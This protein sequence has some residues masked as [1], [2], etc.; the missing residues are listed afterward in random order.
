MNVVSGERYGMVPDQVIA[1]A[2]GHYGEPPAPIDPQVLDRIMASR[3][4]KEIVA[5]GLEEPTLEELRRR[6]DTGDDDDL[7]ILRALIPEADIA[8]MRAAG[9]VRRDYPLG[10]SEVAEVKALIE[11]VRTP[12]FHVATEHWELEL[13]RS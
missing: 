11:T 5:E 10:S 13:R 6:H 1:Y 3:R 2:A 7:L 12:Y 4:A 9:P 8:A